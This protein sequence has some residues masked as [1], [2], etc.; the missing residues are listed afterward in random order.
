M[1]AGAKCFA[2]QAVIESWKVELGNCWVIGPISGA[3]EDKALLYL[4]GL[5]GWKSAS[6]GATYTDMI[7]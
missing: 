3:K 1:F 7:L 5:V 2:R 6:G 4:K